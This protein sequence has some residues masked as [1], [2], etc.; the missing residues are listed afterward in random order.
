MDDQ[1]DLYFAKIFFSSEINIK[2]NHSVFK[3]LSKVREYKEK[4]KQTKD[5]SQKTE[6]VQKIGKRRKKKIICQRNSR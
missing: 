2:K 5:L 3:E 4:T 1:I 6:K